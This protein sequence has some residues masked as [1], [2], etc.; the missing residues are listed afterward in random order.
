MNRANAFVNAGAPM[1]EMKRGIRARKKR[2][3]VAPFQYSAADPN[4]KSDTHTMQH[5]QY[6]HTYI[7]VLLQQIYMLTFVGIFFHL[8]ICVCMYVCLCKQVDIVWKSSYECYAWGCVE[9]REAA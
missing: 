4:S 7:H 5:I 3:F 8:Y 6:I 9:Q 1:N 2:N